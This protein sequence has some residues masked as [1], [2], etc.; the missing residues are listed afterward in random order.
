VRRSAGCF[1]VGACLTREEK[2]EKW[3]ASVEMKR[4]LASISIPSRAG[5]TACYI[6]T[7]SNVLDIR[8]CV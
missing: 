1:L 3:R 8:V 6:R 2:A 5:A 7:P 4:M